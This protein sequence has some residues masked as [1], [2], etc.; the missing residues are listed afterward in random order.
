MTSIASPAAGST[1]TAS[2]AGLYLRLVL[3]ALFWGGTFIAGRRLALEMPHFVA[4]AARYVLASALLIAYL[5]QREGGLPKP[6]A[7]QWIGIG[8]L[9][10]TGIFAYNAFFFGALERLPAGRAALIIA[11]NP[12]LTAVAAWLVFRLRFAWWQWL[13]VAVAFA[14]ASIVVSRGD[15]ASLGAGAI[16]AGEALMFCGVLSWVVYTLVGRAMMRRPDA[17]SPLATTAYASAVGLLLL[18]AV[19]AFELPQVQWERLGAIEFAALAYMG[20]FG[21]AVAFVW[22]Y[23]GVKSLGAARA[24]VFTNLVPVFGV[25]L[26]VLVLGEPLLVSMVVGGLVTMAGVSLTNFERKSA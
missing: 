24:A 1:A 10:A 2:R 23:E 20:L 6:S 4:A 18:A 19:A 26:A 15:P 12:A 7:R 16:G 25:T 14:G 9:G 22:F 8:V 21:T 3:V 5:W 13:G 11:T 17:L